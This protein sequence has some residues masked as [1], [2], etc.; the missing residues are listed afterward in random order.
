[1]NTTR[2]PAGELIHNPRN[3][4]TGAIERIHQ[5]ESSVVRKVLNGRNTKHTA[6]EWQA[7]SEPA[8]WNYWRREALVYN[9]EIHQWLAGSGVRLPRLLGSDN[10]DEQ[11]IELTLE[12]IQGRSGF[13]LSMADCSTIAGAWGRAQGQL[14][15]ATNLSELAWLSRGFLPAYAASKPVN[16]ALLDSDEAWSQPLIAANWP[17]IAKVCLKVRFRPRWPT[18]I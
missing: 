5:G 16:Y 12:D 8:H 7:S 15:R 18:Q 14:G 2:K 13:D 10:T 17:P 6:S 3:A 9:S 4:V 11:T 1:M